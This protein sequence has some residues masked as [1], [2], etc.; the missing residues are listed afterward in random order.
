MP[1]CNLLFVVGKCLFMSIKTYRHYNRWWSQKYAI[2][3]ICTNLFKVSY[4]GHFG[5]SSFGLQWHHWAPGPCFS[6]YLWSQPHLPWWHVMGAQTYL[7]WQLQLKP[8]RSFFWCWRSLRVNERELA[9]LLWATLKP[10]GT[11]LGNKCGST[12]SLGAVELSPSIPKHPP[13]YM[14]FL[15]PPLLSPSGFSGPSW[16]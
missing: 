8:A 15:L 9:P 13:H 1:L 11:E 2:V 3:W 14:W 12:L 7:C 16:T 6:A 5:C 10:W 4:R